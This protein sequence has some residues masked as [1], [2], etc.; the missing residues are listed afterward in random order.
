MPLSKSRAATAQV[1]N[2]AHVALHYW[3]INDADR[4][5]YLASIRADGIMSGYPDLLC[6]P[7]FLIGKRA[8]FLK[9]RPFY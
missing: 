6:A 7:L 9:L 1:I 2:Y 4:M 8:K 3:T 5:A